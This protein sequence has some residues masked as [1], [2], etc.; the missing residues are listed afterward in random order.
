M[1]NKHND[2]EGR[3]TER[4]PPDREQDVQVWARAHGV[5]ADELSGELDEGRPKTRAE[6]ERE[7]REAEAERT[8]GSR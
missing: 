6:A 8:A 5:S 4:T 3:D 2:A 1:S 7:R